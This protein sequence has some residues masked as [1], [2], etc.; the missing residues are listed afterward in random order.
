MSHLISII[1]PNYN[2]E[3]T[4]APCLD[5]VFACPDEDKEV[6]VVDDCSKDGSVAVIKKYPCRFIQLETHAGASAARN[7][8]A[9]VSKGT[10]LFFIDADCLLQP[11]T[12]PVIRRHLFRHV[13]DAV[14]GG[15]Y[16]PVPQDKGFFSLFQSVFVHFFETKNPD[17]PDYVATH[18]MLINTETFKKTGGFNEIF[19]PILEDVE[20]SHRLR[21]AGCR[22]SIDPELQVKHI[23]GFTFL[24]SLRNAARKT[25]FWI[26]YSLM[27]RDL[28]AD[29]GTAARELKT[30][31]ACWLGAI[32]LSLVFV[33]FGRSEFLFPLPALFGLAVYA[34]R[35]LFGLF[36]KTGGPRFTMLAVFYYLF[37][38][39]L[40]VWIGT[41]RGIILYTVLG[42]QGKKRF[43][44]AR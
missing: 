12:I 32:F 3:K 26:V 14:I 8:G 13:P 21:S 34:N 23:F 37:V 39:P 2:G 35:H 20:F 5:A 42:K 38:Y 27:N 31:G 17:R 4:L 44:A 29:S 15:T 22:L 30:A 41:L 36:R 1:I 19:L 40:P 16:T 6:I 24:K 10:V 43:F 9:A 11:D 18:A 25:R 28:F 7:A 33:L